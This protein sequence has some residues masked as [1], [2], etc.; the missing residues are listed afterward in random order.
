MQLDGGCRFIRFQFK[1][2]NTP[3]SVCILLDDGTIEPIEGKRP[4]LRFPYDRLVY[5]VEDDVFTTALLMLP[6]NY[7]VDGEK[8]PLIIWDSGDGSFKYWDSYEGGSY[9]GRLNGIRYLRDQGFAVLEV[10]SWGSYYYKKYPGCGGRS[11]MPIPTHLATHEKGVEYVLSRY[12]IDPE[13]IF[14]VSKSGSGKIALYYAMV[15]P[16]FS[17]RSIYAMA[18]VFDDLNFVGWG[19]PDYRAAL[20][21]ELDLKGDSSQFLRGTPI[22]EGG[23]NG[24]AW[25]PHT[26]S[27][28]A[29]IAQN[30]EKFKMVSVDW[31]NVEGQT[32]EE[33]MTDTHRFSAAFWEGYTYNTET[34]KWSWTGPRPDTRGDVCY[35]RHNLVRS[36]SHIP[37]TVIMSPTD[38]QTPYWNALEVVH[39]FQN[40]G[41]DA[42]MITLETG[43]HSGPDLSVQGTNTLNDVT[44]RLGVHYDNVSIGWYYTVEDIY[45]RFLTTEGGL[46]GDTESSLE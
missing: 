13:N 4:Q 36:G 5:Q 6:P 14:H 41:E 27:Q 28:Q 22:S 12:N 9:F 8:V 40:A 15:H 21:E 37:I 38:E 24:S 11:A 23:Y 39:Q 10:Y 34:G 42:K 18:P 20:Y 29:F 19:M 7:S 35:T 45:S 25:V 32:I 33:K 44:T 43:G 17:L 26:P 1:A 2:S 16:S 46:D 30:A 3:H 31:M